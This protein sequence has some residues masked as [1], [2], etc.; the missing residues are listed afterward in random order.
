MSVVKFFGKFFAVIL[1]AVFACVLLFVLGINL[2]K[3]MITEESIAEYISGSNIF[4]TPSNELLK[5]EKSTTLKQSIILE[6]LNIGIP[7]TT[8][9]EFLESEEL[10]NVLAKYLH[11]Y[12]DYILFDKEKPNISSDDIIPIIESYYLKNTGTIIT[13]SEQKDLYTSIDAITTKINKVNF[14]EKEIKE[15]GID[16]QTVKN[17]IDI[18]FSKE[19]FYGLSIFLVI[20]FIFIA[21]CLWNKKKAINWCSKALIIDGII[22]IIGSFLEVKML[23]MLVNSRGIIDNLIITIAN[24]SFENLLVYGIVLI[25]IG[26]VLLI[27]CGI[28]MKKE[29]KQINKKDNNIIEEQ[30]EPKTKTA[31]KLQDHIVK[32]EDDMQ[33]IDDTVTKLELAKIILEKKNDPQSAEKVSIEEQKEIPNVSIEGQDMEQQD[34][35]NIEA[36]E[37]E[38][39]TKPEETEIK[40]EPKADKP[41]EEKM[42]IIIPEKVE[43]KPE[44]EIENKKEIEIVELEN[45]EEEVKEE[46]I[47]KTEYK[48]ID[49]FKEEQIIKKD[50]EVTSIN[51]IEL[52]I[53]SPKKGKN[54]E[55]KLE[56][57]IE[58][59][60][61]I[62][63]L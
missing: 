48:E 26:I 52:N 20:N 29:Q 53:T 27:I 3:T 61:D 54:I 35:E 24:K 17:I 34:E 59:D 57:K 50:V 38:K 14:G 43:E 56:D 23:S 13:A 41:V 21:I 5:D 32:N 9:Q 16:I 44:E 58:E 45:I 36:K 37:V 11:N 30:N 2:T 63:V 6:F 55:V 40:E 19:V 33:K 62:E 15:M 46:E 39:P 7:E 10:T 47:Q 25:L 22:F 42:E 31:K 1:T 8:T 18:S 4:N 49:D 51:E 28:V 12:I 60:E